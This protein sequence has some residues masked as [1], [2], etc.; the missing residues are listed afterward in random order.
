MSAVPAHVSPATCSRAAQVYRRR[1]PERTALYRLVQQ[2]L[3][4]WLTRRREADPDG[5]PLPCHVERELRG[6]VECG[7][8]ACGFARAYCDRCGHDFLVAFSC[9]GRGVCPSCTTRR[10]ADTATH[11]VEQVFPQVPVRQWV[12]TF[13]KRLRFFLHR[14][15]LRRARRQR[16]RRVRDRGRRRCAAPGH[17]RTPARSARRRGAARRAASAR[18][19]S[20]AHQCR[21][22]ALLAARGVPPVGLRRG[23]AARA[24][25]AQPHPRLAR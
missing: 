18:R 12:V 9:K 11:L 13:P 7:I 24:R 22:A 1:R 5:A 20:A 14:D 16:P 21:D 4:T 6:Y 15:P 23:R 8:L 25:R 2:H 17:R 19:R 3:E 10:M